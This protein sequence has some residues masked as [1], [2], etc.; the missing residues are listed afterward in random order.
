MKKLITQEFDP[1]TGFIE[2]YFHN[3]SEGKI[4]HQIQQDVETNLKQNRAEFDAVSTKGRLFNEVQGVGRKV[5]SIPMAVIEQWRAEGFDI[6]KVSP[7][8]LLRRLNDPQY[9]YLRT[10]PGKL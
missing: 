6:F 2:R 4:I 10:S 5:A 1:E 9:K 3:P 8:D 7:E